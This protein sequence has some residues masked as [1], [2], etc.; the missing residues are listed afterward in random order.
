MH[1]GLRMHACKHARSSSRPPSP[2]LP[3]HLH[4]PIHH[5]LLLLVPTAAGAAGAAA[6]AAAV[7]ARPVSV[8]G[9]RVAVPPQVDASHVAVDVEH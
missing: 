9:Q 5:A 3:A 1:A 6:A 2:S 4:P 7:D 8:A